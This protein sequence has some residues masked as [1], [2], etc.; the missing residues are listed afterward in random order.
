MEIVDKTKGNT[1][2]FE[3]L[4]PGDC[5][6]YAGGLYVKSQCGQEATGLEDGNALCDM[7]EDRVEPVNAEIHIV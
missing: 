5:F 2:Y 1:V 7:C 6:R 3:D 4:E